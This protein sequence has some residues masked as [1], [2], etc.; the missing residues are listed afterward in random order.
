MATQ[1]TGVRSDS[2]TSPSDLFVQFRWFLFMIAGSL[3]ILVAGIVLDSVLGFPV[4]GG[5]VAAF[6]LVSGSL[7]LAVGL[8]LLAYRAL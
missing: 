6:G 8:V 1:K 7:I 3:L 5:L 4:F 2:S